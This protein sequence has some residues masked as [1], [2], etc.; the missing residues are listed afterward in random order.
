[1]RSNVMESVISTFSE[2]QLRGRFG[3]ARARH[4]FVKR[5]AACGG[6]AC[7]RESRNKQLCG[8]CPTTVAWNSDRFNS[9]TPALEV[10]PLVVVS[11]RWR[12]LKATILL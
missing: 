2:E 12:C 11:H 8:Y 7:N 6:G 5:C 9:E 1:M 4:D 10:K 3:D